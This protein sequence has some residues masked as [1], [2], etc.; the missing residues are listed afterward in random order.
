MLRYPLLI[1][2]SIGL[3]ES[4]FA[5]RTYQF[6]PYQAPLTDNYRPNKDKDGT[7]IAG[8][9]TDIELTNLSNVPQTGT[10]EILEEFTQAICNYIDYSTS[11]Y[12]IVSGSYVSFICGGARGTSAYKT[13][14]GL[15]PVWPATQ[16]FNLKPNSTIT[17]SLGVIFWKKVDANDNI[18]K[19]GSKYIPSILLKVDQDAGAISAYAISLNRGFSTTGYSICSGNSAV[20]TSPA[21]TSGFNYTLG[22]ARELNGGRPF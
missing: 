8:F 3:L 15:S 4:A 18:V 14:D 10:V 16:T 13:G 21:Q 6:S 17:I 1:L 9:Q 19:T 11:P 7:F 2:L 22:E 5:G 12:K 20:P